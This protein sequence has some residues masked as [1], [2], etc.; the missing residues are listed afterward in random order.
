M[1]QN[2][3]YSYG[4]VPEEGDVALEKNLWM[5]ESFHFFA[6][7]FIKKTKKTIEYQKIAYRINVSEIHSSLYFPKMFYRKIGKFVFIGMTKNRHYFRF[8]VA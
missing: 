2:L 8:L 4:Y 6:S 5:M 7:I 3:S 1:N